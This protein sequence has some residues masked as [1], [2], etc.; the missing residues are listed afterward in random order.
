M[1]ELLLSLIAQ[2]GE[3]LSSLV[4]KSE[5]LTATGDTGVFL[6]SRL[7]FTKDEHGQDVCLV[8]AGGEDVGVMMGWERDIS[9]FC[10]YLQNP[11]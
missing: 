4:L 2:K 8:K 10:P 5:D 11:R 1:L 3:H 6:E 7:R 9:E